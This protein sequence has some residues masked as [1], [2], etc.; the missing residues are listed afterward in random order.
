MGA[1]LETTAEITAGCRWVRWVDWPPTIRPPTPL[2]PPPPPNR[3]STVVP[4]G[5][6]A[7][8]A[9]VAPRAGM[10]SLRLEGG[11]L[12]G[13][14]AGGASALAASRGFGPP[15]GRG[16]GPPSGCALVI[17]GRGRLKPLGLAL[18]VVAARRFALCWASFSEA[19]C[20]P[21]GCRPTGCSARVLEPH[22]S[23]GAAGLSSHCRARAVSSA[24]T[25]HGLPLAELKRPAM[26]AQ[27][28][29]RL[30]LGTSDKSF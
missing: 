25:A 24:E 3:E 26:Y 15:S 29:W 17:A 7:T 27:E 30:F 23:A 4:A 10:C 9:L 1:P 13:A 20:R 22:D 12:A 5:V 11:A 28:N 6:V 2:H 21:S 19:V 18:S 16:F 14:L 8:G